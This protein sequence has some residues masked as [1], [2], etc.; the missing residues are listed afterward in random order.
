MKLMTLLVK[1]F[2]P[3]AGVHLLKTCVMKKILVVDDAHDIADS[4]AL[5]LRLLGYET[6][7]AYDGREAV[8]AASAQRPD[9]VLLDLNMPVFD[10]FQAAQEIR[11]LFAEIPPTIV[12]LSAVAH[13]SNEDELREC[14][15]D[16]FITKPADVEQLVA[17]VEGA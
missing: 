5:L 1:W 12:A 16:H 6:T 9:V 14:G 10:G 3:Q 13:L 17:I 8:S 11:G 2:R 7:T 15:F 4:T